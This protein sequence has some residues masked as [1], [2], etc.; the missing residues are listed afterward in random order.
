[1]KSDPWKAKPLLVQEI[2][3][4][5]A[6]ARMKEFKRLTGLTYNSVMV[7]PHGIAPS[8]TLGLL[9]KYNFLATSN[10]G[11][12]PIGSV[13][14][15]DPLFYLRSYSI[16][17]ENFLS[18][19][20]YYTREMNNASIL[21]YYDARIIIDIFLDNP[22]L[23]CGHHD[24]FK[25]GINSFNKVA[26]F[27]N[28]IDP[29]IEWRSLGFI[30]KHLYLLRV[31]KD[32]NYDVLSYCRNIVI[33]NTHEREIA[34]FIKKKETFYPPA[35]KVIVN[36]KE[37]AYKNSGGYLTIEISIP[38]GE[39]KSIEIEYQN[40]IN[41]SSVDIS[42][43]DWHVKLLRQISDFRD[44]TLSKNLLGQKLIEYY[45]KDDFYK[46]GLKRFA[47][48]SIIFVVLLICINFYVLIIK[49]RNVDK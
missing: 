45:Y 1:M 37:H 43:N 4:K 6:I 32:G 27:V 15:K 30:A 34:Y 22:I 28:S 40:N 33:K 21:K 23:L 9:K 42:K 31:R 16:V 3:I 8:K 26:R 44:N 46:T 49:R 14:P 11:N 41:M 10:K 29:N 17:F 47:I 20:R 5:Q 18:L 13:N 7:F 24:Y 12:I 36:G 35:K 19:N 39:T 48:Y 25:D 2:N 38:S